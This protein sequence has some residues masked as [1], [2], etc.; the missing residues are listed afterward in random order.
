M[1][2][3]AVTAAEAIEAAE[4]IESLAGTAI[5]CDDELTPHPILIQLTGALSA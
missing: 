5:K 4:Q 1:P 3:G 2:G